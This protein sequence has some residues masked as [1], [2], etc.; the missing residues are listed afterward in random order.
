MKQLIVDIWMSYRSMPLWVQIWAI[1]V[2]FLLN[3]ASLFFLD[4]PYGTVVA[5]LA[6]AG[7][8]PNIFLMFIQRGFSKAMAISHV[9]FWIPL[10][11]VGL[12]LLGG[13]FETS[14]P[15]LSFLAVLIPV[16]VISLAFDMRETAQW[17][18]GDRATFRPG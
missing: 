12:G 17:V 9:I 4:H 16:N 1:F 6:V 15:M 11:L 8:F 13:A 5:F 2:L 14:A 3:V 18:Q 10:V 7:V